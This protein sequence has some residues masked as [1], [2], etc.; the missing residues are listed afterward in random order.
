MTRRD[1]LRKIKLDW[2]Q[3][4]IQVDY[5]TSKQTVFGEGVQ[6]VQAKIQTHNLIAKSV[7]F[8]VRKRVEE[9]L[10]R[11]LDEGVISP[12]Q[13][14][15]W[16]TSIVPVIKNGTIRDYK[17]TLNRVAVVESYLLPRIDDLVGSLAGGEVIF[18]TGFGSCLPA[19]PESART[20]TT[21]NT[22]KGLFPY[23]RLPFRVSSA[24]A[25]FQRIME[26]IL[27]VSVYIDDILVTGSS[28]EQHL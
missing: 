3:L 9:E 23:N 13:H 12:V 22:H 6:G 16:A 21:I 2:K 4:C 11:L 18:K 25:I 19:D 15:E 14:S 24:P 17:V 1:W 26:S 10:H 7:P 8:A 27:Q 28:R 20:L 5:K